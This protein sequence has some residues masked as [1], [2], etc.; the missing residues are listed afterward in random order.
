MSLN[1]SINNTHPSA[2]DSRPDLSQFTIPITICLLTVLI[3]LVGLIGNVII[4]YLFCFRIKLNQSTVYI[5]NLAVA[6]FIFVFGCC[7]VTLFFLCL[8]NG[9]HTSPRQDAV[10][11]V[12]GD[13]LN[14]FGFN[15]SLLFLAA[16]SI[17]RSLS[18]CFPMWYKC[19][20]PE[21]LSAI[22]T[23][24]IWIASFL[25]SILERFLIPQYRSTVYIVISILFLIVT[26]AMIG[27]SAVLLIEIRKTSIPYRPIKLYIVVVAAVTTFL[28]SLVPATIV[29]LLFFFAFIPTG[30]TKILSYMA[31][32]L[33]SAV[34]S[35]VNP[36]IYI[37]VGRWKKSLPTTQAL[38]SVFKDDRKT[39][40]GSDQVETQHTDIE[41]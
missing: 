35:T 28:I 18:V 22:L 34:N 2:N 37:I 11:S 27:A 15:S 32:S 16:L 6:D 39:S 23:V 41:H 10:F 17:E 8:Y 9:V 26:L 19:R 14:S 12:F 31:F 24:I 21:H 4:I 1:S 38:E 13:F 20:R 7:M 29:R 40:E 33:C 30:M 36:Y 25:I 5:L 3:C